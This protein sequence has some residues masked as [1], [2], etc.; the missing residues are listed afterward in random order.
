MQRIALWLLKC[1]GW[2][3]IG[4][5]PD[6]KKYIIIVAPHT[7]NWDLIICIIARASLGAKIKFLAKHQLFVFPF[8][9]FFKWLGG[10]PVN[11][12]QH[13]NRV[14][15][16]AA[17]FNQHDEFI[18][19]LA[20]EGTRSPVKRWKQGFYHIACKAEVPIVM[21]GLDYSTKQIRLNKPFRPSGDIEQDFAYILGYYKTIK[22]RYP[23]EI[24]NS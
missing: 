12:T 14:D 8:G 23:K 5:L 2:R 10:T 3:I 17:I 16:A 15:A 19:G 13:A 6:D 1:L 7:S 22:G 9:W 18:L 24:P 20:P 11:R 21:L 4:H